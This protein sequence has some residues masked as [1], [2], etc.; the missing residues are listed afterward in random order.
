MSFY[1][2]VLDAARAEH[3]LEVDHRILVVCGGPLD[4]DQLLAAGFTDVVVS[5]LDDRMSGDA[6]APYGWSYQDAEQL[7]LPDGSF[8]WVVVHAG[9]HHCVSPQKA[10][11]EMLRVARRGIVAVEAR[12]SLAMRLAVRL[13]LTDEYEVEAVVD[14]GG[15]FGGVANSAVP[16]F[17]YRWTEREVRKAVACADPGRDHDVAFRYDWRAPVERLAMSASPAR[18]ALAGPLRLVCALGRHLA[19]RQGNCFAFV[20]RHRDELKPWLRRDGDDV[21]FD[22]EW[23]SRHY[24]TRDAAGTAG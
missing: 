21:V 22:R 9:L 20:V 15:A 6:Y 10:L 13:G 14:N 18:R 11:A 16:N 23:A 2:A 24:R 8:D 7:D 3:G 12:D 17:V 19:P 1:A 5:N 4:R